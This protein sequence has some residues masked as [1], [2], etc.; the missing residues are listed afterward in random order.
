MTGVGLGAS[1]VDS[2]V[3]SFAAADTV[4]V[5]CRCSSLASSL[6]ESEWSSVRAFCSTF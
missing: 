5:T 6:R 1:P 2:P 4:R 3:K